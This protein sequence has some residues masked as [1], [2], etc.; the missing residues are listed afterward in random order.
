MMTLVLSVDRV[1]LAQPG[2]AILPPG[3]W[4]WLGP[5][6]LLCLAVG[7]WLSMLA[8]RDRSA[9]MPEERAFRVLARRMALPGRARS[10]L[11]RLGGESGIPPVGLLLSR[12]AFDKAA[13]THADADIG[14]VRAAVFSD[15]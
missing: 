10:A 13:G 1:G 6:L 8:W 5:F 15:R 2:E 3:V 7:C 12:A 9:C 14:D 11:R 4:L